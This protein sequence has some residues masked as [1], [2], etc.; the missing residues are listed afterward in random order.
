MEFSIICQFQKKR[1]KALGLKDFGRYRGRGKLILNDNGISIEGRHVLS[2]GSRWGIG[3]LIAIAS[4]ALTYGYAMLGFVPIYL[5]VEFAILKR[6]NIIITWDNIRKYAFDLKRHLLAVD[7]VG[8]DLT[9]PLVACFY[10]GFNKVANTMR[11]IIPNK[12]ATPEIQIIYN[13]AQ[14]QQTL[15]TTS[16]SSKKKAKR[17]LLII[18]GIILF[19]LIVLLLSMLQKK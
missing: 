9:S 16:L 17:L 11:E 18:V 1:I 2:L 14:Y 8:P 13:V 6:E 7:F 12:D 19:I 15:S 4:V 5:L 3:I 10:S